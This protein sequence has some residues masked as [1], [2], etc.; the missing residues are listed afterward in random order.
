[1][2]EVDNEG[3]EKDEKLQEMKMFQEEVIAEI[4]E[5]IGEEEAGI[6]EADIEILDKTKENLEPLKE[7]LKDHI[8]AREA[9]KTVSYFL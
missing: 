7:S 3:E 8:E 4:Q 9:Y 1:M 5:R 6:A 2:N